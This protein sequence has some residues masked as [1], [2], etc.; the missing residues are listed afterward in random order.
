M[1]RPQRC[2]TTSSYSLHALT[3][4][5][6]ETTITHLS[7]MPHELD[8]LDVL[9]RLFTSEDELLFDLADITTSFPFLLSQHFAGKVQLILYGMKQNEVSQM[10]RSWYS[11]PIMQQRKEYGTLMVAPGIEQPKK[12]FLPSPVISILRSHCGAMLALFEHQLLLQG[13]TAPAAEERRPCEPLT[14]RQREVLTLMS[15]GYE[16]RDIAKRLHIS[17]T[18]VETHR[19]NIYG[20]LGVHTRYDALRVGY[21]QQ[22]FTPLDAISEEPQSQKTRKPSPRKEWRLP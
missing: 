3:H 6:K 14:P 16:E 1:S 2:V 4:Q 22:I 7:P 18:T 12:P 20:R 9:R 21:Q 13:T 8:Y 10:V 17:P 11:F 5:T 19:Q 15:Q